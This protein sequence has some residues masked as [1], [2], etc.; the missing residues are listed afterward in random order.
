MTMSQ[1][2]CDLVRMNAVSYVNVPLVLW[3]AL[4]TELLTA[5]SKCLGS[6]HICHKIY[7]CYRRR[8]RRNG[9]RERGKNER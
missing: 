7:Q 1:G 3:C 2:C 9:M 4:D 8:N 6:D 5:C